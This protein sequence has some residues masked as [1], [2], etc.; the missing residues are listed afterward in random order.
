MNKHLKSNFIVLM[1]ALIFSLV[2]NAAHVLLP[3]MFGPIIASIVCIRYLHLDI[4]WPFWL[5]QIG[6]V[7]LGVQIGSTFTKN[8]IF[9]IK[10]DW[11]TIVLITIMLLILALII[12]Y[13][14]KKIANVNTETAILSVIPG[15]LSQMLIMADENKK[16]N[17][18]VVSLTQ[19]SR[20]IFVV[21]LVPFISYF[22]QDSGNHS[23]TGRT[24]QVLTQ[25]L[26]IPNIALLIIAITVIYFVMT[27]IN[28]PTK[29]LLAPILVL[30]GWNLFTGVTFTLDNYIIAAA[31]II[32]MI[33]I[34]IQIAKLLDQMKG[35]IAI[36]IAFQNI[37]LI[38]LAFVMVWFIATVSH[39]QVNE[40][41]LGA[42]PG[43]MSQIVLV[44]IET[45]ADVAMISSYH[46]FRIFF[47]LF[48]IAPMLNYFLKFRERQS[49]S[50]KNDY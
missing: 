31:Q 40:L 35:R 10:D 50:N 3:F 2:L 15:A 19:T 29:Q 16:A 38:L 9:D 46:I 6:L 41:F 37:L 24:T 12:A 36:A 28:F 7:L 11:L 5:S 25:A 42:A 49:E 43:G 20:I 48:L 30:I 26:T 45:G 14:F 18:M 21:I 4:R 32:Y 13:F 44:A 47:I 1:L 22:F 33:R 34:G 23:T 17:I 27:K 39:H 8:V